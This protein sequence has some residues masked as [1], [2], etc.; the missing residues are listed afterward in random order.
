GALEHRDRGRLRGDVDAED[1]PLERRRARLDQVGW[2]GNDSK[3]EL[4]QREA[5]PEAADEQDVVREPEGRGEPVA[6]PERR[7]V[8]LVGNDEEAVSLGDR[9][10]L[11]DL[12]PRRDVAC[13]VSRVAEKER[14][15]A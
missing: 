9:D 15:G 4:R 12:V 14:T 3:P 1:V 2:T 5:L 8:G 6:V 7:L 10:G 11:V 13:R